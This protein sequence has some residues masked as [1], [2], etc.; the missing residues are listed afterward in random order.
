MDGNTKTFLIHL[1]RGEGREVGKIRRK[2]QDNPQLHRLLASSKTAVGRMGLRSREEDAGPA[3]ADHFDPDGS[4]L[5]PTVLFI[6]YFF[7]L[8]IDANRRISKKPAPS[9]L[10][11]LCPVPLPIF[12]F[13]FCFHSRRQRVP[14]GVRCV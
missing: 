4:S 1:T 8:P 5:L 12:R 9:F 6:F 11:L 13:A 14:D 3:V 2:P 10:S 7:G